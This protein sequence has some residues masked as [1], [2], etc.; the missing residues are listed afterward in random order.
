MHFKKV[1]VEPKRRKHV[2]NLA[3]FVEFKRKRY[4][5]LTF[6]VVI[7]VIYVNFFNLNNHQKVYFL[8]SV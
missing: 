2:E 7:L 1:F 5:K 4:Q 3:V 6:L 8:D